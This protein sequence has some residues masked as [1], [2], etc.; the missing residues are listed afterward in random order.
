[1]KDAILEI[2]S[3]PELRAMLAPQQQHVPVTP[4][5]SPEPP[6]PIEPKPSIW[7]RIKAKVAS[8]KE[9]VVGAVSKAKEAVLD[10]RKMVRDTVTAIGHASGEAV[11]VRRILLIAVGVGL[12][13]GIA[14]LVVPQT[15]AAAVGAV[16]V[17]AITIAKC[18]HSD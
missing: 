18:D 17:A 15:M 5:P 8:A 12:V 13:A 2:I 3:N 4:A 7:S 16:G 11:P 1:M 6:A 14:C 9:A 10:R